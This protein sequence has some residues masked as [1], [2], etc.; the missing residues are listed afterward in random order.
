MPICTRCEKV[1]I[2]PHRSRAKLCDECWFNSG[3]KKQ[4]VLTF[5]EEETK[6]RICPTC[7]RKDLIYAKGVCLRCYRLLRR[8]KHKI[9]LVGF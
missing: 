9:E 6:V 1:F 2:K 8:M 3:N 7:R 5:S 4:N